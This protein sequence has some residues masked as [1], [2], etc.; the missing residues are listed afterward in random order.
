[1]GKGERNRNQRA[2]TLPADG[3]IPIAFGETLDA[4]GVHAPNLVADLR[5][6]DQ[7][8][9]SVMLHMV[10]HVPLCL[11]ALEEIRTL[12]EL[13]VTWADETREQLPMD[14]SRRVKSD[15]EVGFDGLLVKKFAAVMDVCRDLMELHALIHDFNIEPQRATKWL[16]SD[17]N[18]R[19]R[20]FAYGRLLAKNGASMGLDEQRVISMRTE[21]AIH[22][23]TLHPAPE[24][25]SR[26]ELSREAEFDADLG[27]WV[28]SSGT[29]LI[30][31]LHLTT[32]QLF[33]WLLERYPTALP[34]FGEFP[35]GTYVQQ[36]REYSNDL[37]VKLGIEEFAQE[38][39]ENWTPPTQPKP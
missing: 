36:W 39:L 20:D 5:R 38:A 12:A 30:R 35:D 10:T 26:T 22:S 34:E 14:I 31:H 19:G 3:L 27:S 32:G 11:Q 29:E 13:L 1:M 33:Q 21:Y 25:F 16:N 28:H 9:G 8:R 18:R 2:T 15:L 37:M 7:V 4:F 24:K 6:D 17:D 23:R